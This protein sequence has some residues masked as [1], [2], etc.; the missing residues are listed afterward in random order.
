MSKA[1]LEALLFVSAKPFTRK[2]LAKLLKVDEV[3]VN[4][5]LEELSAQFNEEGHGVRLVE[6]GNDVQLMSAPECRE[7]VEEYLK[8]EITGELTRPQ[9]ET[10]TII[11]YRGPIS[12]PEVEQIRG[13]NCTL[14]LRNLQWRGLVEETDMSTT[15]I[16]VYRVT[17]DFVRYLG[18]SS[19][20]Q[21]PNYSALNVC[22]VLSPSSPSPASSEL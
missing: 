22:E 17:I 18:L 19:V 20:E 9:L 6:N 21:L 8:E 2:S 1:H 10:L 14:I 4:V 13:I 12:K 7:L 15:E 11:A 5:W 16:P 3:Q